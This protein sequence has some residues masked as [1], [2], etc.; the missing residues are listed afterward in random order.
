MNY[1]YTTNR[2]TK[3]KV[4]YSTAFG[5]GYAVTDELHQFFVAGRSAS[6]FDVCI[7]AL[8]IVTGIGIYVIMRK[9]IER[10]KDKAV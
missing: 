1:A 5:I 10:L 9:A 6:I 3:E 7:D 2:K 4:F 8:G